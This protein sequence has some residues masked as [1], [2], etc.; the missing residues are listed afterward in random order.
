MSI[1][2]EKNNFESFFNRKSEN[3]NNPLFLS[4]DEKSKYCLLKF[5]INK[6]FNEKKSFLNSYEINSSK[7]KT[8]NYNYNYN[9]IK[10]F[11]ELNKSLSEI[12]DFDL[13]GNEKKSDFNSS[14]DENDDDFDDEEEIIFKSRRKINFKKYDKE[15]EMQLD[16]DLKEIM[17]ELNIKRKD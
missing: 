2:F 12:S 5:L 8:I 13:E 3:I 17:N 15:F 10:K 1:I 7:I 9:S 16:K 6:N 11:D 4:K 14:E